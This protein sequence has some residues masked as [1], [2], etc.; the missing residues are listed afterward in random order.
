MFI[1]FMFLDSSI[2]IFEYH[3][4]LLSGIQYFTYKI[5]DSCFYEQ[6]PDTQNS[7]LHYGLFY[8]VNLT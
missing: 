5:Q 2:T 1:V 4:I 6:T 8:Y 7:S 3:E